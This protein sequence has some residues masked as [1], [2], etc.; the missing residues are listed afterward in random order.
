MKHQMILRFPISMILG[1]ISALCT[2]Y[3]LATLPAQADSS[4]CGHFSDYP[5]WADC[6]K[7]SSV[8]SDEKL[9]RVYRKVLSKLKGST[10]ETK[11]LVKAQRQ[12]IA[13]RDAQCE[14][15]GF[16][17]NG[18][19]AQSTIVAGCVD[20]FASQRA[21]YLFSLLTCKEGDQ[22]CLMP[23]HSDVSSETQH[24][25]SAGQPQH[26]S[27]LGIPFESPDII[28]NLKVSGLWFPEQ[29][30][31]YVGLSGAAIF[32]FSSAKTGEALFS[33]A[34]NG[35]ALLPEDYWK[36][37][38]V[39]DPDSLDVSAFVGKLKASGTVEIRL[40]PETRAKIVDCGPKGGNPDQANSN[41]DKCLQ[42]GDAVV[43]IQDVDFDGKKELVFRLAG[44]SQRDLDGYQIMEPYES[45]FRSKGLTR[46]LNELDQMSKI[47]LSKYQITLRE[48]N[49][50]CNFTDVTYTAHSAQSAGLRLTHVQQYSFDFSKHA[51]YIEDYSAE[52]QLNGEGY[53]FKLISRKV[54]K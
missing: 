40:S 46:P 15:E 48:S 54:A 27:S 41:G 22:T 17:S 3:L 11:L 38:G 1:S 7:K 44:E 36:N 2:A 18:G 53:C 19:S 47:N 34:V 12:W 43:D 23:T 4:D 52:N 51:C 13:F 32:N 49:G 25:A 9:N 21:E 16:A 39:A 10:D 26:A 5:A 37:R 35:V 50:A 33:T 20:R 29:L 28:E 42:L 14:L 30:K 8:S 6:E 24:V 45:Y 31:P